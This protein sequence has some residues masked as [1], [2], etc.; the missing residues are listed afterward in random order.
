MQPPFKRSVWDHRHPLDDVGSPYATKNYFAVDPVL[1][2]KYQEVKARGGSDEEASAAATQEWKDF[3]AKAHSLGMKV[4][5]D[6][7]LNHVG[8]NYEFTDLFTRTDA[9][10]KEIREVRKND[11]SQIAVNPE[12]LEVI[13]QR[14]DDPKLPDYMEYVAPW[15]YAS[16][17]GDAGGR[18]TRATSWPAAG[19]GSTPSSSTPAGRTACRTP[20]RTRRWWPTSAGCSSTGRWTWAAT[21]SGSTT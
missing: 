16:R 10:G 8:H 18:E 6:V 15:L 17:T 14:L 4:V 12:Q 13:K 21:A 3:V 11:F 5:V 7:A 2:A 20:K 1:S 9:A 19:S